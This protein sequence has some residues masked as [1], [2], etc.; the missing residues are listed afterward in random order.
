MARVKTAVAKT[1]TGAAS[2]VGRLRVASD[3]IVVEEIERERTTGGIFIPETAE[4]DK[5]LR[6]RVLGFGPGQLHVTQSGKKEIVTV[7]D[8]IG[9]KIA[10]GDVVLVS[11]FTHT[12]EVNGRKVRIVKADQVIAVEG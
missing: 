2:S 5:T 12:H 6:C 4:K 10:N 1:K 8:I 11:K 7:H 9:E 3:Q